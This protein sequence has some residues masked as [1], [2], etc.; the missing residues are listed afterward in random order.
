MQYR[1]FLR[2]VS[3]IVTSVF[4][5]GLL[6]GAAPAAAQTMAHELRGLL[7]TSK[8]M[9]AAEA[10]MLAALER[11]REAFGGWFPTFDV[12]GFY[13]YERQLKGAETKDTKM[14]PREVDLK[15]T[16]LLWDF[17]STN[18]AID[19]ARL[20]YEQAKLNLAATEQTVLQEGITAY[21]DLIRRRRQLEFSRGSEDNIKRQ[22]EL[23][24]ARVQRGSGFSTDVLQAKQQLAGAQAAR[25]R[26][27]GALQTA[28]NRYVSVYGQPPEKIDG[29]VAPR[30]P[31]DLLPAKLDEVVEAASKD[32][33]SLKASQI[34]TEIARNNVSKVKSD[35]FGPTVNLIGQSNYKNDVEGTVGQRH[36]QLV[37]VE[38]KYSLNLGLTAVNTLKAAE[39]TMNATE[40][41]YGDARDVIFEQ[42]KNAWQDLD[43]ARQNAEHLRNQANIAS[44]FL[45]LARKERSLGRRSLIDVLSGETALINASSDAASAETDVAIAV[46][47]VL[48]VMGRL[49]VETVPERE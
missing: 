10:E 29:M 9:K 34:S 42:A 17:G 8:K 5:I 23:E 1:A 30:L 2:R 43:T 37:K 32:N 19:N 47:R 20:T 25:V 33:P 14:P 15:L 41:R 21:L 31:L 12:T 36:E 38:M 24:D 6:L 39:Q 46:Y 3:A 35:K 18:T 45:E 48:A 11:I 27:Q 7:N 22:T 40:L 4:L 28:I 16:Q 13:G 26:A 44:E 49:R